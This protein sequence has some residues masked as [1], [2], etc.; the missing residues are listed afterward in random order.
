[1]PRNEGIALNEDDQN[2]LC[3]VLGR[4]RSKVF[5]GLQSWN[6]EEWE[7][8]K[9]VYVAVG[10]SA[11][12]LLLLFMHPTNTMLLKSLHGDLFLEQWLDTSWLVYLV[13]IDFCFWFF[14]LGMGEWFWQLHFRFNHFLLFFIF[15]SKYD[16]E[17]KILVLCAS[18]ILTLVS[19]LL[20]FS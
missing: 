12:A 1:M 8:M 5:I 19:I 9:L 2:D 13:K 14:Y 3:C 11:L 15:L 6:V 17:G 18:K 4:Q 7:I 20:W 16:F 10:C